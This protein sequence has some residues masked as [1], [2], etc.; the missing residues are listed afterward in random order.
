MPTSKKKTE[1][2][3][4]FSFLKKKKSSPGE[5]DREN[6]VESTCY[7]S[8]MKYIHDNQIGTGSVI[9]G[10]FGEKPEIY[11]DYTASGRN[12][13]NIENYISKYVLSNY[14]N[15][16]TTTSYASMQTEKFRQDAREIIRRCVNAGDDDAVI[17]CGSGTTAAIHKLIGVLGLLDPVTARSTVVFIGPYEHHS[18]I[19]PWRETGAKLVRINE[20]R[21]GQLDTEHLHNELN[22]YS[23]QTQYK[24]KVH[25]TTVHLC[26]PAIMCT[27]NDAHLL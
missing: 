1:S 21:K 17:F 19:I 12:L 13:Y 5:E 18:N 20:N 2:S 9:S 25:A 14:G 24:L 4:R 7:T 16:H 23:R 27:C 15:T 8:T 26:A 6:A 3:D 11:A 10:P 22:Y